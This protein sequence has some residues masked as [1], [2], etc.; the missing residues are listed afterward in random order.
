MRIE[1]ISTG[2]PSLDN[3]LQ[4][5][6]PRGFLV[7]LVGEPGTG[8]T[9]A[10]IHFIA[11]GIKEGDKCVY[12]TT[13]ESRESIIAAASLFGFNFEKAIDENQLIIIDAL[14]KKKDD[15]WMLKSLD[16][17]ELLQKV[18]DAKKELGYGHGRL[19]IDSLSAFWLHAPAMA[20]RESYIIKK[21]LHPWNF[22]TYAVSEYAITTGEAFGF[23]LEHIGDAIFRFRKYVRGGVLRRFLLI[24][25]C[26]LTAHDLR[27]WEIEIIDGVGMVL[28]SPT[29]YRAEDVRLPRQVAEKV[30]KAKEKKEMEFP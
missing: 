9:I 3:L 21:V 25:K 24:E 26:R 1:R 22:T 6:I 7:A 4:G 17:Q 10:S 20:R 15:P 29:E 27:M 13:E 12:C 8:K 14:L 16:T 19:V 18:I 2:I 28:K 5:G 23:G 11:E 30:L